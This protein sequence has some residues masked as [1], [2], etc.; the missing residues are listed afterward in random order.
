MRVETADRYRAG[1]YEM[2][3]E[4]ARSTPVRRGRSQ[5]SYSRRRKRTTNYAGLHRR[6]ARRWNW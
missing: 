1:D 6:R 5:F 3:D 4:Q 2:V